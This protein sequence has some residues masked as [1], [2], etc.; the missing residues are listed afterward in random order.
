MIT[1]EQIVYDA[2]RRYA[3]QRKS[4]AESMSHKNF[5]K[6]DGEKPTKQDIKEA[7]ATAL[8]CIRLRDYALEKTE[9][10]IIQLQ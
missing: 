8:Q 9:S 10:P 7:A 4:F 5:R 3:E 6:P 1:D 2:L